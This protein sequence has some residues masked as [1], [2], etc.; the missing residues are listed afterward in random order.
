M[1]T[2]V[3]SGNFPIA[4]V[5]VPGSALLT[6]HLSLLLLLYSSSILSV[7]VVSPMLCL[8]VF[9]VLLTTC[10]YSKQNTISLCTRSTCS[11]LLGYSVDLF[12]LLC[13]EVWLLLRWF[14]KPLKPNLQNYGYK[15]GQEEET[16]NIVAAHGYFGR[17]IFQYASF[18]NSRS[19]HFFLAA[20]PVVGIWFTAL[21]VSTM[22]FNLNGFN[23]NQSIIDGQ[24]RVLNTWADVLNRAGLGME[25]MHERNA[26]N[27]PLDLA[28]AE[29]TP[30][31]LTA[32]AIG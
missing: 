16:Y 26:H 19:L 7:K 21:G 11:V 23:F 4:W 30:V 15:F 8:L 12:S 32:P 22:A 14:V 17:L 1:P 3:V 9:L 31:A 2:W 28:A 10:L 18:N 24:G 13:T 20:W 27:F 6:A 29:S 25:V 5:C